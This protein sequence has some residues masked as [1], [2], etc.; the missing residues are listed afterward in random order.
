MILQDL[1]SSLDTGTGGRWDTLKA[2][3]V[4]VVDTYDLQ[5]ALGLVPFATTIL[6]GSSD[7]SDCTVTRFHVLGPAVGN[8]TAIKNKVYNIDTRDL[9]GGTPTHEGFLA[10]REVLVDQ[11]PNDG[12]KRVVILVTDGAPNCLDGDGGDG[13]TTADQ[14]RVTNDIITLHDD[15]EITIYVVGYD[16]DEDLTT[17]MNTWADE[18]GTGSHYAADDTDTLLAQ[19][20]TIAADLVPC[21]YTLVDTVVDPTYVRVRIDTVSKPYNNLTDG[22]TLGSDSKTITL[23]GLACDTLRDGG[24]HDLK[25][26]VECQK[27]IIE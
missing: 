2:A 6:D 5:F 7:D 13:S 19:M 26:T 8:A 3:M 22:W 20:D 14:T 9:V 1:S 21:E 11:D 4:Q 12:S 16:L 17:V 27:V 24:S 18:G 23:N 15:D 25:I 10:A